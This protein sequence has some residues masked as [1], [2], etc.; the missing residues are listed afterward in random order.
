MKAAVTFVK[1]AP[2]ESVGLT[3][4]PQEF[5][6]L[7]LAAY[8]HIDGYTTEEG[9]RE[10][11]IKGITEVWGK[12]FDEDLSYSYEQAFQK[13]PKAPNDATAA[14]QTA[15]RLGYEAL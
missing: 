12:A 15:K 7:G 3:L 10:T 14:K 1:A 9:P 13:A 2:V 6:L 11:L 8:R 5:I 4:T